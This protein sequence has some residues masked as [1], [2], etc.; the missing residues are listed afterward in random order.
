MKETGFGE[1]GEGIDLVVECSGA[2]TC[3]QTGICLVKRRGM[4]VQ[5]GAG[6][7]DNLIP[8]SVLVNKYGMSARET[9]SR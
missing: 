9:A 2:E 3:V 1:R 7:P 6:P 8:M 5:V 4:Y